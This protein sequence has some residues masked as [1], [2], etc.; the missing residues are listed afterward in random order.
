[1]IEHLQLHY[2]CM[3]TCPLLF[4]C[5]GVTLCKARYGYAL[6][7]YTCQEWV[8]A[9]LELVALTMM[10]LMFSRVIAA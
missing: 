6:Y 8:C 1:M 4:N 10:K 7:V 2:V 3:S 9:V 5:V